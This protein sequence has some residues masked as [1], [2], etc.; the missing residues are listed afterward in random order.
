MRLQILHQIQEE[1]AVT[2][3]PWYMVPPGEQGYCLVAPCLMT[4]RQK[5]TVPVDQQHVR[6]DRA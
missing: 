6:E 5:P 1:L 2:A 4:E 3:R